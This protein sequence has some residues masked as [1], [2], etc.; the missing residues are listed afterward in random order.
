MIQVAD[1]YVSLM[2]AVDIEQMGLSLGEVIEW[3]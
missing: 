1:F 2:A 3:H